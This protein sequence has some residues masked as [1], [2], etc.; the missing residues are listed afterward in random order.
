MLL[1]ISIVYS[2]LLLNSIPC[3]GNTTICFAIC[4]LID[5]CFQFLTITDKATKHIQGQVFNFSNDVEHLFKYLL[6][7]YISSLGKRPLNFFLFF[8]LGC[9]L[10]IEL[11]GFFIYSRYMSFVRYTFCKDFSPVP[12]CL[13]IFITVSFE[14][15]SF[16]F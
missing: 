4:L 3:Y 5:F 6:A 1:Y 9:L 8:K 12:G 7:I 15:Q 10:I 11:Q 13:F 16:Q 2:F 14:E